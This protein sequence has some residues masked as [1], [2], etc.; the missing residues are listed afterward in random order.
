[1]IF[2]EVQSYEMLAK[3]FLERCK[4]VDVRIGTKNESVDMIKQLIELQDLSNQA[5]DSTETLSMEIQSLKVSLNETYL[6]VAELKS[7]QLLLNDAK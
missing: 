4:S 5:T 2:E 3:T 1:M 7:K 6:M